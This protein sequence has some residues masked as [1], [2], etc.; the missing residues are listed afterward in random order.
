MPAY[1]DSELFKTVEDLYKKAHNKDAIRLCILWQHDETETIPAVIS[2]NPNIEII[3]VPYQSSKGCNWARN[4]LQQQWKNEKYSLLIDSHHRF[5]KGWDVKLTAMYESLK[6]QGIKKPAIT[7]YLPPYDPENDP[8]GRQ[9]EPLKIYPWEKERTDG[10]LLKVTSY[11]IPL[12]KWLS[13]PIPA[14]FIS[15]HFLFTSGSFNREIVFDPQTYFTGDEV[16]A[17]V[18]AYS[19]GY[20]LFHPHIVLGWHVY[21]RKTRVTHWRDHDEWYKLEKKSFKIIRSIFDGTY[22][23]NYPAGKKRSIKKYEERIGFPLIEQLL[24]SE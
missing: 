15:L 4:I 23:G 11:P 5:I 21:D 20:D 12:W 14:D 9:K 8:Q 2:A 10:L 7:A 16:C 17:S 22:S 24:S 19:A 1:R 3:Q 18:R 6:Q 13:G